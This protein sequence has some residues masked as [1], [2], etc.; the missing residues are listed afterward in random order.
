MTFEILE[1]VRPHPSVGLEPIVQLDQGLEPHPIHATLCIGADRHQTSTPQHPEML[2]DTG[3]GDAQGPDHIPD[4][5]LLLTKELE[6]ATTV[7]IGQ[8]LERVH[9]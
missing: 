8:H 7:A 6:D 2:G 9:P 5:S 1:S 4:R 3:L